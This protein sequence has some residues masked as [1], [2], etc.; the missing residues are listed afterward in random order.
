[1][2]VATVD[3]NVLDVFSSEAC[4][5]ASG[6]PRLRR[7]FVQVSTVTG[8]STRAEASKVGARPLCLAR[9]RR[10]HD[11][12]NW[13]SGI[14]EMFGRYESLPTSMKYSV[15]RAKSVIRLATPI[16]TAFQ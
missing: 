3:V 7:A 11:P 10:S 2:G 9:S 8:S 1:M 5:S 4:S 6:K 15:N 12:A 13:H 14:S 16:P